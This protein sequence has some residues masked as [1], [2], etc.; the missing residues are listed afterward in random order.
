MSVVE[1][2]P[3]ANLRDLERR[4]ILLDRLLGSRPDERPERPASSARSREHGLPS[5]RPGRKTARSRATRSRES[6]LPP[7]AGRP[8]SPRPPR[9]AAT[10]RRTVAPVPGPSL[11]P[12]AGSPPGRRHPPNA[13][14]GSGLPSFAFRAASRRSHDGSELRVD[15]KAAGSRLKRLATTHWLRLPLCIRRTAG[16]K[17]NSTLRETTVDRG[18]AAKSLRM[19]DRRRHASTPP[20]FR[21][22]SQTR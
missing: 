7:A 19:L 2:Q 5:G 10:Q 18:L 1:L 13:P 9:P 3:L 20:D 21:K 22:N 17:A 15:A 6:W 12:E 8:H 11:P 16:D 4:C 14:V